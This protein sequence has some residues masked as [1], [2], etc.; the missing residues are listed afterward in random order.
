MTGRMDWRRARKWQSLESKYG[1]GVILPNGE[2]TPPRP[3]DDLGRRAERAMR[4][5]QRTLS[6]A[7]REEFRR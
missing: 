2:V 6:A 3:Q 1:S 7:D 4:V 5:W